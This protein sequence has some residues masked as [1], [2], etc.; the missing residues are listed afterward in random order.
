MELYVSTNAI[1]DDIK[2]YT[3]D[4]KAYKKDISR[5]ADDEVRS[6][7]D[8]KMDRLAQ[9]L[10]NAV[11]FIDPNRVVVLGDIFEV[12]GIYNRFKDIY[13]QYDDSVETDFIVKS[14]LD[15][16]TGHVAPVS[17]VLDDFLNYK[18]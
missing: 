11:S 3:G 12:P 17:M 18:Y 5:L 13:K 2:L 6:L 14:G 16:N 8:E 15:E 9:T 10:R 1:L 7:M 4:A